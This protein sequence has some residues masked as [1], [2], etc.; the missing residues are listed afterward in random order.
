LAAVTYKNALCTLCSSNAQAKAR[1]NAHDSGAGPRY[2]QRVD[3]REPG[4]FELGAPDRDAFAGRVEHDPLNQ[5]CSAH[6]RAYGFLGRLLHERPRMR[7]GVERDGPRRIIRGCRTFGEAAHP[8]G[9]CEPVQHRVEEFLCIIAL[10]AHRARE[11]L[12]RD[13]PR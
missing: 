7:R 13:A 1:R 8:G 5:A 6:R 10:F 11:R 9:L 2:G 3:L 12:S 4:L